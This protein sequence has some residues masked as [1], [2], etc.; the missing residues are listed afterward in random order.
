[1]MVYQSA[2]PQPFALQGKPYFRYWCSLGAAESSGL[3]NRVRGEGWS[4]FFM[5][6]EIRALVPAWGAHNTLR[7]GLKRL[8]SQTHLKHFN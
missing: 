3:D 6:G 5:V 8:L 7:R 2:N 4:L 1:M